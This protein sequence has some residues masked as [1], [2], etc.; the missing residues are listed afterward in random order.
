VDDLV[1]ALGITGISKSEVSRIGAALDVEV[2]RFR[3]RALVGAFPYI[4]VDA[5]YLKVRQ[6]GRVVSLAVVIATGVNAEGHRKVL[7]LDVGPSEEQAFW[8]QFLRGLVQRGLTG[9]QLVTSDAHTGLKRAVAEA[10]VGTS[11]QRCRVHF[12]RNALALVPKGA[13]QLVAA[14]IRTVCAQPDAV[15]ARGQWRR[16][17]DG[18]RDRFP[19][20]PT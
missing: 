18:F 5:T 9:V 10:L 1:Q 16:M 3:N 15:N 13:Q 20:L 8:A 6:N 4:W 12:V 11:W 2:S 14:T 7:G 19:G 17:A